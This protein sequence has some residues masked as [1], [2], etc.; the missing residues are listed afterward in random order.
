MLDLRNAA[1]GSN[2]NSFSNKMRT[3]RFEL[4][5][6]LLSNIPRPI[7]IIDVGGTNEFWERRGWTNRDEIQITTINLEAEEKKFDNVTPLKGDATDMSEFDDKSFDV[8]IS[9]SVIE[10]LFTY[11]A[12]AAMAR[13]VQR[14]ARAFWV[15]TPN[16]WF[17]VEP[18][19]HFPAWQWL[20]R[21][22]RVSLIQKRR[23]GWRG[24]CP[25]LD[26]AR[27]AVDEIRLMR[28]S[29]LRTMFPNA[30]LYAEK[31][32]G[33]TKSFVVYEGFETEKWTDRAD[34][35]AGANQQELVA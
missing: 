19:F 4:F 27:A 2:P 23:C 31:F 5:E 35:N 10:H 28:G 25:N 12:Q 26:D 14:V 13:E 24:P 29:E 30:T 20:P 1:N 18:H 9:N 33:L 8:A 7:R 6:S 16:F 11:E 32:K 15:Q 22:V 34:Q 21:S 17:P 3:R